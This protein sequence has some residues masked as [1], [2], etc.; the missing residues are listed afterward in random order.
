[1]WSVCFTDI[2]LQ[3]YKQKLKNVLSEHHVTAAA[4]KMDIVAATSL[5]RNQHLEAELGL[6]QEVHNLRSDHRET[7]RHNQNCM[8]ELQLVSRASGPLWDDGVLFSPADLFFLWVLTE[9]PG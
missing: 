9:T 7:E 3:V 5:V 4:R 2:R 6:R 8:K 1:M